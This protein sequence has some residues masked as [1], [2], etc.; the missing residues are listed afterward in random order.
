VYGDRLVSLEDLQ[1]YNK[2]V[3]TQCKRVFPS[4][5]SSRFYSEENADPL[6]FCHFP[7]NIQDKE[8]N[9]V[10]DIE[11]MSTILN[12]ALAEYNDM[13]A[14]MDLVLFED[15]MKHIAR[16][17]RIIMNPGGHALLVGVGGSGKQSLSR[18][19]A[20]ICGF[21]VMQIVIS[22]TYGIN[23]LKDDLKLMFQK[24]GVKDE[25]VMFLLT[26]SQITN[27][28][29]LIFINDLLASGNIPD[30]F[31]ADEIDE[32]ANSCVSKVKELGLTPDK[33]VCWDYFLR[34]VR[35][36]LHVVLAFSPV[37]DDFRTRARKFPALVNC[38]V[39]D[40]FQPWPKEALYSVGKKYL[41]SVEFS[42]N[43]ERD[44]VER[45]LPYSF[46]EVNKAAKRFL[47]IER[48]YVYTTPK[49][50]LELLKLYGVLLDKKRSEA[51]QAIDRLNNGLQKL[52][53]TSEAVADLE[54]ILKV[55][56][57]EAEEK[58]TVAEGIAETV[59]QEKAIVE[60]ETKKAQIENDQ[61]MKIQEE[62]SAK[63]R[64]TEEDLAKA[65]PAVEAA[66]SA[67]DTLDRRELS[68]CKTMVKPPAGVDDIF[69]ATMVLLANIH[70]GIIVQKNGKVKD[71]SW[72]AAKKQLLSNVPGYLDSLK[73]LKEMID[74]GNVPA[75]NWRE[76][77]PY[78]ELEHF[79]PVTIQ[80]KNPAA[81]GLCTFILN[82]VA[83]NEIVTTVEP[84]KQALREANAELES[85]N[86]RLRIVMEKVNEL[87]EKLAKLTVE[88]NNANT[89]KQ[90]ALDSVERGQRKLDLAQRLTTALSAENER[91][92]ENVAQME[93]DKML[94]T[95]D[96]LLASAFI[97]YI[98]P[99]TKPFRDYL[100]SE[101]F[102]VWLN[103]QFKEKLG[104]DGVIPMSGE[105]NPVKILTNPAEVAL[106]NENGLPADKVSTENGAIVEN[107]ARWPLMI[108][109]Q[110]Q[111][112]AWVR[113]KEGGEDRN[114]AIVRLGQKDLLR[115]LERALENGHTILIENIGES[116]DAVLY[117]VIQRATIKRG[118]TF[119]VKLGDS[120]VEMNPNFK[121]Y[122]HTKLS[123][124]HYPPEIQAET[125]LVNFTV[126]MA[127]LEDQLLSLVVRK[128]RAD[129]AQLREDLVKQ[130]N[131]F[132]IK[133][134]ELE[135]NILYKLATAEGD[136]TEDVELI[137]GLEET[138]RVSI[139]I[140]HKAEVATETQKNI[141]IVSEK[142]RPVAN[143]S[144][145]L[146]FL[147]NEL[148]K[149]HSYYIYS[150]ASFTDV[151]YRGIDKV[152]QEVKEEEEKGEGEG[153]GE[154]DKDISDEEMYA[155]CTELID[156][157]TMT[158]FNYIRRGL[159]EKD[160]LMVAVLLT[161]KILVN[162]ELLTTEEVE[163]LIGGKISLDPGNMGPLG[164]WMPEAIWPRVKA[165]EG[166]RTFQRLGDTMQQ[167]S[168]DWQSW[169][170]HETPEVAKLPGD[171]EKNVS[172]FYK[173]ILVRVMRPDRITTALR[174]WV[175]KIMGEDFVF[176]KPFNMA[177]TFNESSTSTP[178]F[179]VLFPGVDPTPWVESLGKKMGISF[180]HGNFSNISM[181]Q[182]QE[183]PAEAIIEKYSKEGGWVM[184]Q[185]C[186]LMQTWVPKLE[187]LLEIASESAHENFR[188]FVSAEPPP[189][190]SMKN[191]PES[192]MQS[193]I[194]I[195]NQAPTDIKSNLT[196]GWA[197]FDQERF[198][199]CAKESEFKGCLF[200]LCWFHSVIVARRRFGFQG[201]SRPYSF[202]MGD[203]TIS[204]DVLESYLITNDVVPWDDL[205]YIFGEIMYGGH[206]T[207]AWDRRTNSTYL[208]VLFNEGLFTQS[209]LAP[210][211]VSPDPSTLD[212][213]GYLDYV[214]Q[215]LPPEAP[216]QFGLHPNAEIGYLTSSAEDL[217]RYV[218]ILGGATSSKAGGIGS[219]DK[220]EA[221]NPVKELMD[222]LLND[223]PDDFDMITIGEKAA[224]L[225]HEQTAPFVVV[226]IQECTRMNSLM[227]EIRRSLIE[228]DKGM[229]GQLNISQ[230]MED[231]SAALEI[232]EWPG[233]DPMSLC[234][235]EQLAWPS[236]KRLQ[237]EFLDMLARVQQLTEWT[238]NM[239]TPISVWLSGLFNPTAYLT[240][241][242]QVT[243]RKNNLPLDKMTIETHITMHQQPEKTKELGYPSDGMYV[244]GLYL[245][246]ARWPS[247]DE[248][249]ETVAI[250]GVPCGGSLVD[251][252]LKELLPPLPVIYVKAVPVQSTWEPSAVGYLRHV[253]DIYECPVY[254][255][256]MRGGT[257]VF[258][259]T[260]ETEAPKS[261]WVLTGTAILM[262]TDD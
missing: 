90:D 68:E 224:P 214:D 121:L 153:E 110:L 57:E 229:K 257:Y 223:L 235:W 16:I 240:A 218:L 112:I 75:I 1:K 180:E 163:Y 115:K 138:K 94:L 201:W 88:L 202:N 83:Y 225:L 32:I 17:V 207:D 190:P 22:G 256:S 173:L 35:E 255:T 184:L 96:V 55:A 227:G 133:M 97:S 130:Q 164:E 239:E 46:E 37:G 219:D 20:F 43:E 203:L 179:F 21:N 150:L 155:R 69:S 176:Q 63:Q 147:M 80:G 62:V 74:T 250:D 144:S 142:Y 25:G 216:P 188:C 30:L 157:I 244:H 210:A 2:I 26:D 171:Y 117:P 79:D 89:E 114:L 143:R 86:E 204:A 36:N 182:G 13:N 11:K 104:E 5:D 259:S 91:W 193:C 105:A 233:R 131:S 212:Y 228:L 215:S 254:I 252:R 197:A 66:M 174:S 15:A 199:H 154:G 222:Q 253:D 152:T 60:V 6:I 213:Q 12:D 185:N 50:F 238:E 136:I 232:N 95:G 28:R 109:P 186:H 135:D 246:G 151:F 38:T 58:K 261:K 169:F 139:D 99:F 132:K 106:W 258:L 113:N 3:Q 59:S 76:V 192:L 162:D 160:K 183:A 208:S 19:S 34:K 49:S 168:D 230:A 167:D 134:K 226:A 262:Q 87:E 137:E 4:F 126:T 119:Y 124:P 181:G 178:I 9:Q 24:A 120:E 241:I 141:E 41:A 231:L 206:I 248:I 196:R 39:I 118:R 52:R 125:T 72:G 122:L 220:V 237:S 78:L 48:R 209:E 54:A 33:E 77:Q 29:F 82:I 107:S 200:G 100:L 51:D 211:F 47:R 145:L 249:E 40:W 73:S 166:L 45:F 245:E 129:L 85:A 243:S 92:A 247:P 236:R 84:K 175:S 149:S 70:P 146:F 128:E 127:G 27:E 172:D 191:M 217:F 242:M 53:E 8:Y 14:V 81:A 195:A 148:V 7:E 56:L 71:R 98:G 221:K 251:G 140:T 31:A 44:I 108:D 42:S 158:V 177:E 67:L 205:R 123:N 64:D 101:I 198:D 102:V 165:L 18:L 61:V 170:D 10:N 116:I 260:L 111:G 161:I 156:S 65:I 234:R 93:A 159:F 189:L 187:R 23:D 194:K 103:T